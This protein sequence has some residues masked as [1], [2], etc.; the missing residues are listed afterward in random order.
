MVG[1]CDN[2]SWRQE[3]VNMVDLELIDFVSIDYTLIDKEFLKKINLTIL[4]E[5]SIH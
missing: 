4:L 1:V 5:Q 2:S 3:L